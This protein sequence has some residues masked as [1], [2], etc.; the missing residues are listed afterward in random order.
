MCNRPGLVWEF[1]VKRCPSLAGFRHSYIY[2]LLQRVS[3][4]EREKGLHL[5]KNTAD[6]ILAVERV[7][8]EK[9]AGIETGIADRCDDCSVIAGKFA[10]IDARYR[11][12][13]LSPD[14][15][16]LLQF[17]GPWHGVYYIVR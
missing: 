6:R 3:I 2:G 7:V 11:P 17:M 9:E 12:E 14:R 8:Q 4:V 13:F 5:P 1:P 15:V 16:R 10:R